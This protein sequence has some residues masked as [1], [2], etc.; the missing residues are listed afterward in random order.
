MKR[1]H[2]HILLTFFYL[3][4]IS[5]AFA[6][7][8][9]SGS[10]DFPLSNDLKET[11]NLFLDGSYL[12]FQAITNQITF[13]IGVG[14]TYYLLKDDQKHDKD[15][16]Q[17]ISKNEQ[18]SYMKIIS[19]SAIVMN[20]PIFHFG[21]YYYGVKNS[22]SKMIQFSKELTAS[23]YLALAEAGVIS[24]INLHDRPDQESAGFWETAFRGSSSFPSGHAVPYDVLFFKTFQFYG[25]KYALIPGALAFLTSYERVVDDKHY[26]SDVVASLFISF[27][28]SEGVRLAAKKDDTNVYYKKLF[29]HDFKLA[30]IRRSFG[31]NDLLMPTVILNF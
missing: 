22:D 12:Q 3:I 19:D 7:D 26:I 28:A 29:E 2:L 30:V 15:W 10:K 24:H 17:S 31:K 20:F 23:M 27:W 5:I 16:Q 1:F 18:H 14:A 25:P 9:E 13:P 21:A 8:L 4:T 11:I 6:E